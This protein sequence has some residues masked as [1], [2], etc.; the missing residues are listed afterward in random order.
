[1]NMVF[2]I[3]YSILGCAISHH[4]DIKSQT[5]GPVP[6]PLRMAAQVL[7]ATSRAQWYGNQTL[8]PEWG[9]AAPAASLIGDKVGGA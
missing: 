2:A 1:M 6:R 4:K 8:S 7:T 3:P 9:P 5:T